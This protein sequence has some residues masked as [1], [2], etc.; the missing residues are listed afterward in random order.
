MCELA[1]SQAAVQMGLP[2]NVGMPR[3]N[4]SP[5]SVG[6]ASSLFGTSDFPNV[7]NGPVAFPRVYAVS[8]GSQQN[9]VWCLVVMDL[10]SSPN[11]RL[12]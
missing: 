3:G 4:L 2:V 5:I 11:A 9:G 12:L 10:N 1:G 6:R 8:L 7:K